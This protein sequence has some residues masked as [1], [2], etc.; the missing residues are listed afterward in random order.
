M[1][2][3]TRRQLATCLTLAGLLGAVVPATAAATA[4]TATTRASHSGRHSGRRLARRGQ[5]RARRLDG[6]RLDV[7]R[8]RAERRQARLELRRMARLVR[9]VSAAAGG[10][11]GDGTRQHGTAERNLE[12]AGREA[13]AGEDLMPEVGN[14]EAVRSATLC[15]VNQQRTDRGERALTFNGKL[16]RSAQDHSENMVVGDYVSHYGPDDET[17]SQRMRAVGY[18]YSDDIGY[19]TGENIAWGTLYLATP[20]AI[21]QAWMESPGHRENILDRRYRETA[22]GVVAE[23]P[24]AYAEGQTGAIYTQDFGVL[25][26][27]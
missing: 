24:A 22:V 17:P 15:L 23:V 27:G 8:T 20:K 5:V 19:E 6:Q 1:L 12:L 26:T 14:L 18:I 11:A 25:I 13:C 16:E 10:H 9:N 2:R 3:P 4:T 21:V 7:R